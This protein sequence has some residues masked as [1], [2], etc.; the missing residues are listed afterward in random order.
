MYLESKNYVSRIRITDFRLFFFSSLR[1]MLITQ[2]QQEKQNQKK[3]VFR[4]ASPEN[5][6]II[7]P[8]I[9]NL[10]RIKSVQSG[11]TLNCENIGRLNF[12]CFLLFI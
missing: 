10:K 4:I 2:Q 1:Y 9:L 11:V 5:L 7:Q 3:N 6:I 8:N 12:F